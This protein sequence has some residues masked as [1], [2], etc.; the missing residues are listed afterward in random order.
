MANFSGVGARGAFSHRAFD[1]PRREGDKRIAGQ[2]L[3]TTA[4]RETATSAWGLGHR[5]T[6]LRRPCMKPRARSLDRRAGARWDREEERLGRLRPV[7]TSFCRH[8]RSRSD[9]DERMV[10]VGG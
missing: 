5:T 3:V 10:Y 1:A 9:D 4:V 2:R 8:F 7:A 6:R